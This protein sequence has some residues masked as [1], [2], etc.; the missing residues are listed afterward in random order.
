MTYKTQ[1]LWFAHVRTMWGSSVAHYD[2]TF[3]P[4]I[5]YFRINARLYYT[6]AFMS[7]SVGLTSVRV[8]MSA[9]LPELTSDYNERCS[10]CRVQRVPFQRSLR[11]RKVTRSVAPWG[12]RESRLEAHKVFEIDQM[13]FFF[14]HRF[15]MLFHSFFQLCACQYSHYNG[16]FSMVRRC[17]KDDTCLAS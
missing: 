12:V 2:P 17:E 13:V 6:L 14:A 7:V 16:A 15:F 3:C 8:Q 10:V 4:L 11:V 1:N 5:S 9:L